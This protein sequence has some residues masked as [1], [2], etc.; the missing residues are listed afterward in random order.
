MTRGK[1]EFRRPRGIRALTAV[2][3]VGIPLAVVA[4][5]LSI[6]SRASASGSTTAGSGT[7]TDVTLNIP[8][9]V[10]DNLCNADVVDLHGQLRI[11]TTT[12]PTRNGGYTVRSTA[13]ARGLQGNRIAPPPFIGYHG[14]DGENTFAYYAPPPYPSTFRVLHWTRLVPEAANEPSMYL[15]LLLRE[16]V[17]ADGTVVPVFE[18][19]FL[20]CRRPACSAKRA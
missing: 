12:T 1:H 13:I 6:P 17:L 16:T 3:A 15:V 14:D 4:A 2:L 8:A 7:T 19:A 11:I 18:R 10:V 20:V 5:G 9:M